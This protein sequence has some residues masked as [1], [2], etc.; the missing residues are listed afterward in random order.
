MSNPNS[1]NEFNEKVEEVIVDLSLPK[2]LN[3]KGYEVEKEAHSG[4]YQ[5]YYNKD[6]KEYISIR[7]FRIKK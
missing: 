5:R 4:R 1:K 3:I 7:N 6:R 2:I